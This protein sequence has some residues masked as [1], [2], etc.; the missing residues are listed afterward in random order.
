MHLVARDL[1]DDTAELT[2]VLRDAGRLNEGSVVTC[3]ITERLQTGVSHLWFLDVSYDSHSPPDLPNHVVLKWPVE[4]SAAPQNGASE[5]TFYRD[6][7]PGMAS[8]PIVRCLATAGV[9][10]AQQWLILEDLRSTHTNPPW[11]T[12][13]ADQHA[14]EAVRAL[15]KVHAHWWEASSLGTRVGTWHTDTS[16]RDMVN[17][18]AAQLP[19]FLNALGDDLPASDRRIL[20]AVFSSSLA[21]W[22]RLVDRRALTV[23][24]GDAHTW[25]F[26]FPRSSNGTTYLIDW[27]L[28]H[29]DVG[30]RDL[31]FLI[32][33]HWNPT[34][35]QELELLLLRIY[36]QQLQLEGI[37]DY[38]FEELWRD[39]RRCVVRNLTVPIILWARGLPG[40]AW[41]NRLSCA[42]AAYRDLGGD[43]F[44]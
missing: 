16:L 30:A 1:A 24:H 29:L 32:A 18:V 4:N 19:G 20:E 9:T 38:T 42:L 25:N 12:R 13:P 15:A 17:G 7:A 44:L 14:E 36:H 10:S 27:Q 21:P 33:L 5:T 2:E 41:R 34:A 26:L 22:L 23:V 35:R 8:P 39:Y 11:P 3:E 28:W 31:A 6:L 43:E 37:T 40:E